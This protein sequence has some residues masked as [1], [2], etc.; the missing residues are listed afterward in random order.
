MGYSKCR[1]HRYAS[2]TH[3][4]R[5]TARAL[6]CCCAA[7]NFGDRHCAP[8]RWERRL[9]LRRNE[10]VHES[11]LLVERLDSVTAHE[12]SRQRIAATHTPH[13]ACEMSDSWSLTASSRAMN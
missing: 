10:T 3:V 7:N 2:H 6:I 4:A 1:H 13:V 9:S 11:S 5:W 8:I 12:L